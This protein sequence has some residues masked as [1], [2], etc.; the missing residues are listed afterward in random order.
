MMFLILDWAENGASEFEGE[1]IQFGSEKFPD[2]AS[3]LKYL[4][5]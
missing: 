3:V 2:W 4:V 1:L 5:S